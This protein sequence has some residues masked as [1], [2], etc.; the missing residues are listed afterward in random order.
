[1]AI[2][3]EDERV[4]TLREWGLSAPLIQLSRGDKLHKL[5]NYYCKGP[6]WYAYHAEIGAPAGGPFAPLWERSEV[7]VGVRRRGGRLAFLQYSFG[8]PEEAAVLARTEQGFWAGVFDFLYEGEA[9]ET[10]LRAAAAA[11]GFRFLDQH[12]SSR[13]AAESRVGTSEGH[14][15]WLRLLVAG[16]DREAADAA[17]GT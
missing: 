14:A 15:G 11:V 17:P 16:I 6:P 13:V 1:M 8:R 10:E 5:F 3:S 2:V 4:A 9:P 7:A 12:L